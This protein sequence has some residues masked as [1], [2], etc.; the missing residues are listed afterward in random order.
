MGA[1]YRTNISR[2][3]GL[4]AAFPQ[5]AN[6]RE[7]RRLRG[8][9]NAAIVQ[10]QPRLRAGCPK[11]A[12]RI[13]PACI[14]QRSR[15]DVDRPGDAFRLVKDSRPALRTEGAIDGVAARARSSPHLRGA[16]CQSKAFFRHGQGH[17]K[18]ATCLGLAFVAMACIQHNRFA[19]DFIPQRAALAA[20]S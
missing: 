6:R 13:Q 10:V 7:I 1:D 15:L 17:A 16:G 12:R 2:T 3:L 4:A 8:R 18:C 5:S 14:V 20:P 19:S 9:L 11:M